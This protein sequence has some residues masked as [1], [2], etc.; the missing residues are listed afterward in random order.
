MADTSRLSAM[1]ASGRYVMLDGDMGC[2]R[3]CLASVIEQWLRQQFAAT[4]R[5]EEYP[6]RLRGNAISLFE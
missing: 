6:G 4:V 3:S 5:G 1:L 2:S